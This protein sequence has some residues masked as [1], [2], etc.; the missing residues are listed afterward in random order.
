MIKKLLFSVI[1]LFIC[2]PIFAGGNVNVFTLSN[3]LKV[4]HKEINGNPLVTFQL[5]SHAGSVNEKEDQAG[6]ANFTQVLL[7]SGT[8]KRSSEQ[9]AQEI[10]DIGGNITSDIENDFCTLGISLMDGYSEKA[11]DILS[12]VAFNPSFLGPEIEKERNNLLAGIKSRQDHIHQVADD[13][14]LKNFYKEHPYSWPDIGKIETVSKFNRDDIVKWHKDHFVVNDMLLVVTGSIKL[15]NVKALAEKYF[16]S[17]PQGKAGYLPIKATAAGHKELFQQTGKFKQAYLMMGFP[18]PELNSPDFPVL[19][20]I[21]ALL[22]GRMSGRLFTELREK[23]SLAYEVNS[24]YPSKR[25]MSRFVIYM[26]LEKQNLALAKKRIAELIS[27]LKTVPVEQKELEET[28]NYIRGVFLL[29]HQTIGRKA[30]YLGWW[31]I[32]GSGYSYDDKYLSDLMAV[33]P[34]DIQDAA[35]KYFT[36]DYLQVEIVPK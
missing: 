21:N 9:L 15:E 18:V 30:W 2:G 8:S 13:M 24:F 6:L 17:A 12:D 20:V 31:E 7:L 29:D 5:F 35:N 22:G 23:L 36:D 27:E 10:E 4:I 33:S 19:K 14:F 34:K 1:A 3:G 25:E 26:G 16:S 11:C 32:M 28:K